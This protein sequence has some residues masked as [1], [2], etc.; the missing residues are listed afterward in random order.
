M[1][2]GLCPKGSEGATYSMLTTFGNIASTVAGSVGTQ[3]GGI[4]D[5]SN[6]TLRNG[7]V[8]GLWKLAA[9][10]S[11]IPIL[12]LLMLR[13]LPR[14]QKDQLALQKNTERSRAGGVT[15]LSVLVLSLLLVFTNAFIVLKKASGN[16]AGGETAAETTI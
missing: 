6:A 12:P 5:V 11:A 9:L 3:F 8:S 15:F 2:M 7:D 16:E 14:D 10:T 4:W 1:Y 13:L